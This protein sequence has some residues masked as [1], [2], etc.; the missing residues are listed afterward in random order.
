MRVDLYTI[1]HKAQRFHLFRLGEAMGRADFGDEGTANAIALQ[2]RAWI[3]HLRDHASNEEKY[4]HPLLRDKAAPIEHEH[5]DL[6]AKLTALATILDQRRWSELYPCFTRFL[7]EYVLHLAEEERVQA[8]VLWPAYSDVELGAV[9]NRFKAER[10]PQAAREDFELM[11]P[12]MSAPE[13]VRM[14]QGIKAS[15]P[16]QAF[17]GA[18]QTAA[19]LVDERT[20]T[21]VQRAM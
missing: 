1:I 12:A 21:E 9:F 19:R 17:Q 18:C 15:A 14:F 13:L 10:A 16:P 2:T 20:W 4:I 11:L 7:G 8:E 6:D 5:H 3:A